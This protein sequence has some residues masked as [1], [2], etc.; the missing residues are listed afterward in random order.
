MRF[1]AAVCLFTACAL[2]ADEVVF[3][4]I[5]TVRVFGTVEGEDRQK[6]EEE[7]GKK[8]ECVVM[9]KGNKYFWA[10]R[11]NVPLAR[12][13]APNFTYFVHTGGGGYVKVFT[14]R[15]SDVNAPADYI[16]HISRGFETITYWGRVPGYKE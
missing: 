8:N 2:G 6:L 1:V 16:E 15:R 13:D 14:G 11:E 5:P 9:R 10:S 3:R 12:T 4:G 7:D